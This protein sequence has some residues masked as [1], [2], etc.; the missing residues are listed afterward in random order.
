MMKRVLFFMVAMVAALSPVFAQTQQDA[1]R[2]LTDGRLLK[3][4]KDFEA[5]VAK[6][7]GNPEFNYWLGQVY[8]LQGQLPNVSVQQQQL[9]REKAKGVFSK[10]LEATKQNPLLVVA[11]GQIDLLEGKAADART[12][13]DA[14]IAATANKKNKKYGD[15]AILNAIVRAN[16]VG[17]SRTGDAAYAIEKATQSEELQGGT[18]DMFTSLGIIYLKGG[19]EN[20]GLA[21]RAFEKALDI[22][23]N[24]AAAYW[25][26]GRIFESQKNPEMFLGFYEKAI[27]ANPRFAPAYL[28]LYNYYSN[29]DV[30]KAK[31]YLDF[32][33]ANADKDRETD[34]FYADYLFRAGQYQESL[35]KG[36]EI[37]AA[38]AGD[39]FPKVFK[40]YAFNYDRLRDSVKAMDYMEKYMNEELPERISGE[41]Y[42]NMA[43]Y[44]LKVPGNTTKA[45]IVAEKAIAADTSVQGK[46][47]IMESLAN[48]Y[49]AQQEWKGYYKWL[50][51][52]QQ[53][54]PDN[55]ARA[56]YFLADAAYKAKEYVAA[57]EVATEYIK[58]YPDQPQGYLF[59][60]RA[61]VAADPDTSTG[62]A[63]P[64]VDEYTNFLMKDTVKNKGRIIQ[65]H[66]YKV[67]YYLV[68]AQD[69]GK[70]LESANAIL[71]IDPSNSYGAMA[72]SE[73]ERLLKATGGKGTGSG[74]FKSSSPAQGASTSG[75]T[76]PKP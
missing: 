71:A 29:R 73:A 57:Q 11:M 32:F 6:E 4:Q 45:E 28:S 2:D 55:S 58:L 68:K 25:R 24:F 37:E 15:P 33:I 20:G 30:N 39:K 21:K 64:A 52:K 48:A 66:G 46:L 61:A 63:I 36:Q 41:D 35:K 62:S 14:A 3:A 16:S 47:D 67:Y 18:P 34:Y 43:S 9:L 42:A 22:D 74:A 56:Y 10:G 27:N 17:D 59:K 65:N 38:L 50:S 5:L 40:L 60:Y 53:L 44:Y 13:F 75:K 69:Y 70:A 31:Q 72:K 49:S 54:K 8:L 1:Y 51:R 7:P 26:V 12:K 23:P 19:G 76:V